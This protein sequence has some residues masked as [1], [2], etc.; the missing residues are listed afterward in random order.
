VRLR[1]RR[2]YSTPWSGRWPLVQAKHNK[3]L[4]GVGQRVIG[5]YPGNRYRSPNSSCSSRSPSSAHRGAS[6]VS[7][8]CGRRCI[9]S[10]GAAPPRR[11]ESESCGRAAVRA[12]EPLAPA[13]GGPTEKP[14]SCAGC[15]RTAFPE[16]NPAPIH[17][18]GVGGPTPCKA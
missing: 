18:S 5:H 15:G 11:G 13:H 8:P 2:H 14:G 7:R 9:R 3:H 6:G 10:R 16:T 4:G 1:G 17:P 12:P